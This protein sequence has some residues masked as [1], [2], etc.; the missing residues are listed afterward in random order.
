MT[1][2][3]H[4]ESGVNLGVEIFLDTVKNVTRENLAFYLDVTALP[5]DAFKKGLFVQISQALKISIVIVFLSLS[6][7]RTVP[8]F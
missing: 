4:L 2:N 6:H 3:C 7:F 8:R 5:N 1:L